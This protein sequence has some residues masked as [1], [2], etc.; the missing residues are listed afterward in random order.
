MAGLA[1][2]D[3]W[4]FQLGVTTPLTDWILDPKKETVFD[5]TIDVMLSSRSL[6]SSEH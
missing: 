4:T 5:P 6:I 3:E 2:A 1:G